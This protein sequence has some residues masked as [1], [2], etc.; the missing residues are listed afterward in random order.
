MSNPLMPGDPMTEAH[1]QQLLEAILQ[2]MSP[3][4]EKPI[5]RYDVSIDP[6]I[7]TAIRRLADT[8]TSAE[9]V[10][11][12]LC[13]KANEME[14]ALDKL[15]ASSQRMLKAQDDKLQE[16]QRRLDAAS[17]ALDGILQKSSAKAAELS[18]VAA[19]IPQNTHIVLAE[20]ADA[21]RKIVASPVARA[22]D[23]FDRTGHGS[24]D[25]RPPSIPETWT[26]TSGNNSTAPRGWRFLNQPIHAK[27]AFHGVLL[28]V[29]CT[30]LA[31][32]LMREWNQSG[33]EETDRAANDVPAL[34]SEQKVELPPESLEDCAQMFAARDP[35]CERLADDFDKAFSIG[36][37]CNNSD[38]A[39]A[40]F[41]KLAKSLPEADGSARNGG[42]HYSALCAVVAGSVAENCKQGIYRTEKRMREA[43]TVGDG[44]N[45]SN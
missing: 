17:A 31:A 26:S 24:G 37:H 25:E 30:A 34:E 40:A 39:S 42:Y 13:K 23:A 29:A 2:K 3:Q 6:D 33:A 15:N 43:G 5:V 28:I 27:H 11:K 18:M 8:G 10:L 9:T 16:T 38:D 44:G 21:T 19:G 36:R 41:C 14:T 1:K 35:S 45:G 7:E 20:T 4:G 12:A 32:I 22:E